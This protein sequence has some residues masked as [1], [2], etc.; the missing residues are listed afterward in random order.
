M[1]WI[2][3]SE[4][5]A[6]TD[7]L[8]K[9]LWAA[10]D[11]LR[12]NSGLTSAQYSTPVLGLIFLR[13]AEVR[14]AKVRV[15]LEKIATSSRRGSRVDDPAA[16]HAEG[17]VYLTPNARFDK[18]LHLPEG[19]NA[20]KAINEAMRDIEKHNPQLAGVLPK[21][22]EIFTG[23]LLKELLK[24][25]S[26]IP[27]TI[28]YDAFGRIY[29][30][31]LGE[32][33][34]TEGQKGGEFYTPSS[35]VRLLVEVL[36]PFHGRIL[37]PA[38]GSGGMF[39]QSARFVAEH[40]KNPSSELAI[41][42]QEKVAA[43][44]ALCRMNLAMHGLEG[45]IKEAITYYDDP[46]NGTGKFDFV[47]ANPPFNVNAVDKERLEAEVGKGRRYPFGLPRTDNANYLWIQ[48]FYSTLNTTGRAGFVMANSAS[49]ARASE[50]DLRKQLIEARA[51]DV[52]VAVGPNMFYTVTL[53][54]TLWFLDRGKQ[55]TP[56]ADKVLFLD[57]RH[58]YRQVDRAH[59]D[60]TEGQIGFL[61]NVVRLYR[62][63]EPDFTLG[64]AEAE[65]KLKEFFDKKL[66]FTDVPGLC[67]AA[68][69]KEIEAQGWSLNP[70]RYVGVAPGE[71]VSDEDFKEQLETL[72]EELEKLN[73]QARE[74][75]ETI[76]RNVAE[77]LET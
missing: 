3:P 39:V 13:F 35:I 77:I 18:L 70:G 27:A 17:V 63:E 20:G 47:L 31:F 32:F 52:M 28:S 37:D 51:V 9:R 73:A 25:V 23:T 46:H 26:E 33:A 10:A 49:D 22:Y 50:Q 56:R 60:W 65:A 43:T 75:E 14:F 69:I 66:K 36:E 74:L 71:E 68:T 55:R 12:A 30:Y 42:G 15:G 38:C 6:A 54:C 48:L 45:D 58:I 19:A 29:E 5:D 21:T 72:N 62:G 2:A 4:K 59:R 44:V 40:K 76:A 53:P 1:Q 41:H 7:T 67:K 34:R 11:Q 16:Y 64:G 57:A 24:R 8:E 61:A